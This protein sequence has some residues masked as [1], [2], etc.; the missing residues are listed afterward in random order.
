V[1]TLLS[2]N[3]VLRRRRRLIVLAG[4]VLVA[5]LG[6][7]S[8]HAA[9]PAPH[10]ELDSSCLCA[11]VLAVVAVAGWARAG[12]AKSPRTWLPAVTALRPPAGVMQV[13]ELATVRAGPRLTVALR[14]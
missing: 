1:P 8:A 2:V 7:L 13:R 11:G 4:V 5:S 6:Y 14:R 10:D 9:L 12:R 3:R